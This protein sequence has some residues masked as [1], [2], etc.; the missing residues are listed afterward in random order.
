MQLSD[1]VNLC[2]LGVA[3]LKFTLSSV[4]SARLGSGGNDEPLYRIE[5]RPLT[6]L[7]RFN[8]QIADAVSMEER[9]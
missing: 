1:S 9:R 4:C 8:T 7:E 3:S 5:M 2:T 6:V